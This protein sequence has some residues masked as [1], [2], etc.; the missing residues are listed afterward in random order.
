MEETFLP[1]AWL[2]YGNDDFYNDYVAYRLSAIF[3]TW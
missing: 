2:V 3:Q 1:L